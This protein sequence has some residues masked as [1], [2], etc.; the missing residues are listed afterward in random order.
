M[1]FIWF[2]ITLGHVL[3]F[4]LDSEN[5]IYSHDFEATYTH[6]AQSK[7]YTLSS[8][9]GCYRDV[10]YSSALSV[11]DGSEVIFE[12]SYIQT[13]E[14]TGKNGSIAIE[15]EIP[16]VYS[17]GS[18][19]VFSFSDPRNFYWLSEYRSGDKELSYEL[20][21]R[22]DGDSPSNTN[23]FMRYTDIRSNAFTLDYYHFVTSSGSSLEQTTIK[24]NGVVKMSTHNQATTNISDAH[25]RFSSV[26]VIKT[27]FAPEQDFSFN[28]TVD[29]DRSNNNNALVQLHLRFMP[30]QKP[31]VLTANFNNKTTEA[32]KEGQLTSTLS[33][34]TM[35]IT[36]FS[37]G[38]LEKG[39]PSGNLSIKFLPLMGESKTFGVDLVVTNKSSADTHNY[40]TYVILSAPEHTTTIK[41]T[42]EVNKNGILPLSSTLTGSWNGKNTPET[43][44]SWAILH[45]CRSLRE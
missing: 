13:P 18:K 31:I 38:K 11:Q 40:D 4:D 2:Q 28:S 33:L 17:Y 16:G 9:T 6:P 8:T 42:A 1:F 37:G 25:I 43:A 44:A 39:V 3:T 23:I 7:D 24:K 15:F 20:S 30:N 32:K 26:Y 27:T 29:V 34:P 45:T 22:V 21:W 36:V 12:T 19:D 5:G 41:H 14:K 35:S 10:S